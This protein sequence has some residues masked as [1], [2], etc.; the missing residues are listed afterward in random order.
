MIFT[1]ALMAS[2]EPSGHW[3]EARAI[4]LDEVVARSFA[5]T[6]PERAELLFAA[7]SLTAF[8]GRTEPAQA[9]LEEAVHLARKVDDRRILARALVRLAW[10]CLVRG[11]NRDASI[12][13]GEEGVG[14]ARELDDPWV[15]AETT[16]DLAEVFGDISHSSRAVALLQESLQLRRSIAYVPGIAASLSNLGWQALLGED[17]GTAIT[18]L[19]ES[20]ELARRLE[21]RPLMLM[22]QDNLA[23]ALLLDG[24]PVAAAPLFRENLRVCREMDDK[25]VAEEVLIG[26][27]GVAGAQRD[28]RRAAWLAGA[29]AALAAQLELSPTDVTPRIHARYLSAARQALGEETYDQAYERG[30]L[31]SFDEAVVYA[32]EAGA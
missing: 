25:R 3:Q 15:L 16:N 23:V 17:Y 29:A 27:A 1:A 8:Q 14:L 24:D 5:V 13:L 7:G 31:A 19:E 28:W 32:L 18:H 20:L 11:E 2:L 9:L 26:L 21:Q 6:T 22:I 10:V 4:G 12:A 30:R